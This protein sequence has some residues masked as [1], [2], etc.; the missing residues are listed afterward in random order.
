MKT[1]VVYYSRTG[2][3]RLAAEAMAKELGADTEEL[4]EA[5]DRSGAVGWLGAG[6]DAMLKKP[7]NIQPPAHD[8]AGYDLVIVGTPVWAFTMTPAVRAYLTAQRDKLP[9]LAAF[10]TLGGSGDKKTFQHITELAGKDLAGTLALID[11]DVRAGK[12]LEAVRKFASAL[13]SL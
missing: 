6:K 8:P 9:R 4:I 1:L 12:H 10:C 2:A 13:S 3:T 7:A 11:K 5:K